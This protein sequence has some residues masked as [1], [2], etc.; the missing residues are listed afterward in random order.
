MRSLFALFICENL[1][2]DVNFREPALSF[3]I[4]VGYKSKEWTLHKN[5]KGSVSVVD[6]R[7]GIGS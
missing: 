5:Q 1:D 4:E 7:L 3:F 2:S 6:A